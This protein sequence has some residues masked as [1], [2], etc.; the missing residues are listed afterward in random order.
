MQEGAMTFGAPGQM[1]GIPEG[2][3]VGEGD[4]AIAE[5]DEEGME[6]G[7]MQ[8][9]GEEEQYLAQQLGEQDLANFQQMDPNQ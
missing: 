6:E 8:E 3:E 2:Q 5:D 9:E 7:E 1:Q 4:Q